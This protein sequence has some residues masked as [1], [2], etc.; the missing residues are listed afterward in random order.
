MKD[1]HE[2]SRLSRPPSFKELSVRHPSEALLLPPLF[3][4][5][6][7]KYPITSELPLAHCIHNDLSIS[8]SSPQ[9]IASFL[10]YI[11]GQFQTTK[12]V[13]ASTIC[14]RVWYLQM[15]PLG[16]CSKLVLA[17]KESSNEVMLQN[18]VSRQVHIIMM[19]YIQQDMHDSNKIILKHG[20]K[21][22][23][24][25]HVIVDIIHHFLTSSK[26]CVQCLG[27]IG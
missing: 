21:R 18:K 6:R 9:L 2:C 13:D 22:I 25:K 16:V 5:H 20:M 3:N 19:I 27:D 7:I 1:D 17:T 15:L 14:I 23:E 8:M 11:K 24:T 10:T 4:Q 26:I 12:N